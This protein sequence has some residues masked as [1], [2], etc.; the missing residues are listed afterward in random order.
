MSKLTGTEL[1]GFLGGLRKRGLDTTMLTDWW[2]YCVATGRDPNTPHDPATLDVQGIELAQRYQQFQLVN[3]Q[4]GELTGHP[5]QTITVADAVERI[6]HNSRPVVAVAV[7]ETQRQ[8][9]AAESR[10]GWS[11]RPDLASYWQ[12]MEQHDGLSR[13]QRHQ[14]AIEAFR[15]WRVSDD[16]PP[17]VATVNK[18]HGKARTW[19]KQQAKK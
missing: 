4:W 16:E 10:R 18:Y 14:R 1:D 9:R 7:T 15:W 13:A 12:V 8:R 5:T 3:V 6:Q 11:G 17:S 19:A 2:A